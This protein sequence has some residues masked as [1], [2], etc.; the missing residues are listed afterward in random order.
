MSY[1]FAQ[2]SKDAVTATMREDADAAR[3]TYAPLSEDGA[4]ARFITAPRAAYLAAQGLWESIPTNGMKRT[5]QDGRRIYVRRDTGAPCTAQDVAA[6]CK[7]TGQWEDAAARRALRA[8]AV[9]SA[10][11][12]P[13]AARTCALLDALDALDTPTEDAPKPAPRKPRKPRAPR[14]KK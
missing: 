14:A 8:L 5:T 9:V 11:H 13:Y 3:A 1:T 2:H 7:G 6:F 10:P 12:N 4:T